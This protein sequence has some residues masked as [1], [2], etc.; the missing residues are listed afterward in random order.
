[1][2]ET[3]NRIAAAQAS[4]VHCGGVSGELLGG[5]ESPL[6]K[7]YNSAALRQAGIQPPEPAAL[8]ELLAEAGW[9][10]ADLLKAEDAAPAQ[11]QLG[12]ETGNGE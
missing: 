4:V 7:L 8:A 6:G 9:L 12:A 3:L 11:E 5:N 10:C 1:M 2:G